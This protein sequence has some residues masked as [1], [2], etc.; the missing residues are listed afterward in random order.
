M[1]TTFPNVLVSANTG[2]AVGMASNIC[3]FNLQEV[4]LT[5][6]ARMKNPDHDI[7]ETMPA[8]DFPTG[9]ELL[10]D[11][12]EMR[13]I[14]KTGRGSFKVRAK[15]RY[16]KEGNLIEIYE[17]PYTT[18]AEAILDK[19]SELIRAGKIREIGDM[20]DETD[21]SGLKLTI[22]LKRGA[23]PE[24]LMQK[25]FRQT[26]L[27]DSY[28][29]N[30]NI[31]IAGMPRVMGVGEILEEWTAWRSQCVKR[32]VYFQLGKKREKLHLLKGLER[33][34]LDIDKAIT[35]IRETELEAEVIPNLMI[36]F[37]ID[38]VQAEFVAEIKL[39][40]I[41]KEYILK[42]TAETGDL[43]REI[44]DLEETLKSDRRIRNIIIK[45]LEQVS[46]KFGQPRKTEILYH[47]DTA[48]QEETEEESPDYPVTAFVSREG[49]FKKITPQSLRASS[50]QRFKEGDSLSFSRETTNRAELL[51]FTD[52][53]QCYKARLSDFD[54]GKASQ[55]GDYL[56]TKLAMEP[57]ENVIQ[58]VFPGE[59]TGWILFFFE[60]GKVAKVPMSAY[61]T[62][63]NRRK[64]TGAYSN[65]SP[66]RTIL[67]LEAD[68]TVVAYSTDGRAMIF[69]TAQLTP[70]TTR[71]TQGVAVLTL[72]KKAALDRAV[73]LGQS[74]IVNQARY[75]CRALPA[76]GAVLRP[77]DLEEKQI[78]LDLES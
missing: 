11:P 16:L 39:R 32:R 36:G 76:A 21:L 25:L 6:I 58:V 15:W 64:L 55:L 28:P 56:P 47:W 46:K 17:I 27:M 74:G 65:K 31:L 12:M 67:A 50:E 72:R 60:N 53:F 49:Y 43:E 66:V 70:K 52:R 9:G 77:E 14:Y 5:A 20:R 57:G 48:S 59:Y 78:A 75:K 44:Q 42:R 69:S 10:Y 19:V 18:T 7:L 24:K 45:E 23:D 73:P 51:V 63:S 61:D 68:E 37:G 62:K 4:C 29:C 3:G 1:P 30:F 41:N 26:T 54:D 34:L 33:I 35:I 40:N 38:Q 2:I 71:A 13:S 22:D 8:P